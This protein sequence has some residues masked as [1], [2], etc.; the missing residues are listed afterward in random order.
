MSVATEPGV[1]DVRADSP[2]LAPKDAAAPELSAVAAWLLALAAVLPYWLP[3]VLHFS[4]GPVATGYL[5][6]DMPY[7]AANGRA[8]FERGDGFVGP[9]PFDADPEAPAI[10]F[11]WFIWLLGAGVVKAGFDPGIWFL[12]LGAAAGLICS[13]TTLA[14][15][16]QVLPTPAFI[17]PLFLL[18]M[19]GG[20]LLALARFGTN[21]GAGRPLFDD[22]LLYDPSD[23][24]WS[25]YWGR[26]LI[27]PTE[28]V[29]HAL[30]AAAWLAL[31]RGRNLQAAG[32]GAALAATHPFSGAQLLGVLGGWWLVRGARGE[33]G[34]AW[35]REGALIGV[36]TATFLGYYFIYLERFSQHRQLKAAWAFDW[37][38]SPV[39]QAL[40][41]L[42]PLML[43]LR[44]RANWGR[45]GCLWVAAAVSLAL[46][47]HGLLF[48]P[49]QPLHFTRGYVWAPL[50]L[51]GL[52]A[53][54]ARLVAPGSLLRA[55]LLT[56]GLVLAPLDNFVF[57]GWSQTRVAKNE[58]ILTPDEW[59]ALAFLQ[60]AGE[61]GVLASQNSRLGYL[62]A[63]YTSARPLI[64]H[65]HNTPDWARRASQV[66]AWFRHVG[67]APWLEQVDLVLLT[68]ATFS[69]RSASLGLVAPAW[70]VRHENPSFVIVA[71][72]GK[73][74]ADVRGEGPQGW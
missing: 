25:L 71:R 45:T 68:R 52:P 32:W 56:A 48:A 26:T 44:A 27:Y 2:A 22:P 3:Y 51:I 38:A 30:T 67:P 29:Y 5:Y 31:L 66:N 43:A 13:R 20:G 50:L 17:V 19:W 53:L 58:F 21:L 7:Y 46:S 49:R 14:L 18:V 1:A 73:A 8:A 72:T 23:G 54:Q 59:N 24:E 47:N 35:M 42:V 39:S 15:V 34:G 9:N 40:A 41:Y 33:R 37:S 36:M 10:Y 69:R 64:G 6:Y 11:Q 12:T 28:A 61:R 55:A 65:E 74:P 57:L 16:R 62:A 4:R 70:T 60:D 63:T